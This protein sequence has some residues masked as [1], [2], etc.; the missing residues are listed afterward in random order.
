MPGTRGNDTHRVIPGHYL[1]Q[2]PEQDEARLSRIFN[3]LDHDGNG[4]I[5]VH[6]LSKALHKVGVHKRYAEV[7]VFIQYYLFYC[8]KYYNK[9]FI[10]AIFGSIR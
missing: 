2:L 10:T 8:Y 9:I 6:D 4:R 5:D 3:A 7:I 1:H